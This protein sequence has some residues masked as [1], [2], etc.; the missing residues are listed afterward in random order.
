MIYVDVYGASGCIRVR[1]ME[2][3]SDSN[4]EYYIFLYSHI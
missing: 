1:E 3:I 2:K 4:R